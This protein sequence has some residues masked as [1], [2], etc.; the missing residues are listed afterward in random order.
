MARI[1][2]YVALALVHGAG[3]PISK[4]IDEWVDIYSFIFANLSLTPAK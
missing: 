1:A 3:K 4:V 2:D